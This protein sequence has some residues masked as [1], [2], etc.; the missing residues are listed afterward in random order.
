ME[1]LNEEENER[2]NKSKKLIVS[3]IIVSV[4]LIAFV[5][6]AIFL[7]KQQD[8]RKEKAIVDGMAKALPEETIIKDDNTG[9][10]YYSISKLAG[11]VNYQFFNGEY[12]QYSEDK[13]KCYVE[14]KDEIAML[15]LNSNV[16]YKNNAADKLNFD[17]Y[18]IDAPV[19]NY[20]DSLYTTEKGI[21][22]ALNT[23]LDYNKSNNTITLYTMPYLVDYYKK[24][25]KDS[26]FSGI[27]EEF[28]SQR[29]LINDM[30]VISR[31]EKFGVISLQN[32]STL[33][34][35]KYD[36]L[37]YLE[38]VNEF[39]ATNEGKT[40]V[41]SATGDALIG[42]H[43]QDV[44]LVDGQN[45]LYFVKNNNLI[46]IVNRSESVL[47]NIEYEDIGI[48]R[49]VYP[50]PEIKNDRFLYNNCIPLKKDGKWGIANK[51]GRIIVD[52]AYDSLGYAEDVNDENVNTNTSNTNTVTENPVDKTVNNV[53]VI[54]EI[55]G[56]VV[57]QNGKYGIVD[58]NG[59]F[60]VPCLYDKIYSITN[61]GKHEYYLEN[62]G[63]SMKLTRYLEAVKDTQKEEQ[64]TVKNRVDITVTE[65]TNQSV[66]NQDVTVIIL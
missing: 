30:L 11:L 15:E 58:S 39:I 46:G 27:T 31:A 35:N 22:I 8:N 20:K 29:A 53:V 57:G 16:I 24:Y 63:R 14:C 66:N 3:S 43:Y 19:I 6:M 49:K 36:K 5:L 59:K 44:G 12:K 32:G 56:I 17:G 61:E 64:N 18:T 42:L 9:V 28:L 2:E 25:A 55:E 13:S 38:S 10:N 48:D 45:G 23:T 1:L 51:A 4:V 65:P 34:G 37:T 40:G 21:E 52:F 41:L 33:I 26:G 50:M 60:L 54:P 7:L 62:N 47:L